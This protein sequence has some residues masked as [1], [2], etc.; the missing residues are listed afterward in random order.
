MSVGGYASGWAGGF[1]R[2]PKWV[3]GAGGIVI[4]AILNNNRLQ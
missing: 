2:S 3:A 1:V 4:P